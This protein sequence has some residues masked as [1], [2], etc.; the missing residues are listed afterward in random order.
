MSD[1]TIT[2]QTII[3]QSLSRAKDLDKT[4]DRLDDS[5]MLIY[6]NK[7]LA[8]AHGMLVQYNSN[9]VKN[10]GTIT[11]TA[12]TQEY[13]LSGN[14]DDFWKIADNEVYAGTTDPLTAITREDKIRAGTGTTDDAPSC[15]Y[16]TDTHIGV[17]PI[18]ST[19]GAAAYP[20]LYCTYYT[21][22]PVLSLDDKMPYKNI[23]NDSVSMLMD[24]IAATATETGSE[25][26]TSFYN[27]FEEN[28]MSII[29]ARE[30][31]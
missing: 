9:I 19:T 23:L 18:P 16:I 30:G 4:N 7:S 1:T 10:S 14:L 27:A 2:A 31:L 15:Y 12:S 17:V 25:E 29:I 5:Q 8:L 22:S 20:T 28:I 21:K 11:L 3:D 6:M 26:F 24:S 13:L